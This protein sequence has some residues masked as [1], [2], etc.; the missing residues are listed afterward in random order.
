M[1]YVDQSSFMQASQAAKHGD[2]PQLLH[3]LKGICLELWLRSLN[4]R[5]IVHHTESLR[6]RSRPYVSQTATWGLASEREN[7]EF[8]N[9]RR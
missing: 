6:S 8:Q 5:H 3:F 1:G 4:E 7:F 2:A 9:E